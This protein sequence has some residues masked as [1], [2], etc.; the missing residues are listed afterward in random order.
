MAPA[1]ASKSKGFASS[2]ICAGNTTWNSKSPNSSLRW[3]MSPRAIASATSY[4]SSMVYGAMLAKVCS[5]SQGQPLGA[6]SRAMMAS[7]SRTRSVSPESPL[8]PQPRSLGLSVTGLQHAPEGHQHAGGGPPDVA[9]AIGNVVH[10]D[11]HTGEVA[12]PRLVIGGIQDEIERHLEHIVHFGGGDPQFIVGVD[13]AD[14]GSHPKSGDDVVIR[15][16][17]GELHEIRPQT[18]FL[19]GLAQ[20]RMPR[21]R[22]FGL[23]AP[24]RK[25][26]LPGVILERLR[27]LRQQH[28]QPRVALHQGHEHGGG[29]P[30]RGDEGADFGADLLGCSGQPLQVLL[31]RGRSR[32]ESLADVRFRVQRFHQS[33]D[34]APWMPP[35][36][37]AFGSSR[38]R[39]SS[40]LRRVISAATSKTGR[41][42]AYAFLAMAAPCS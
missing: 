20:R 41:P 36:V 18:D 28:G 26:D 39:S 23:D 25:A 3:C 13:E 19:V 22:I 29:Y 31:R 40:T 34:P 2:A 5:R 14:H 7:N 38:R 12:P 35:S 32:I 1:T 27:A 10:I 21:I 17:S 15:Q 30:R 16:V 24:S 6:R 33:L 9:V 11:G 37:R 8:T 4:A 42:S